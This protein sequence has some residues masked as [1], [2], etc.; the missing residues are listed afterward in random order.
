MKSGPGDPCFDPFVSAED[1]NLNLSSVMLPLKEFYPND[2]NFCAWKILFPNKPI[3]D[4]SE[5]L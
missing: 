1:K 4:N 3:A 5:N 2:W